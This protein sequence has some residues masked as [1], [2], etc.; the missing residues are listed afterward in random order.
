MEFERLNAL[1]GFMHRFTLRHP[2]I[3]V[4]G[5]RDEVLQRLLPW[6]L[7]EVTEMGFPASALHL[8]EQVHGAGVV[9]VQDPISTGQPLQGADGMVSN[10]PGLVLGI[11][12]ADCCA[13]FLADPVSGAF[14]LVHSGKKGSELGIAAVAIDEMQRLG[15][16]PEDIRVQLSPC[17]RPPAYEIDF[18]AQIRQDCVE[19]GVLPA[20]L[21]DDGI[22]TA[23]EVERF[24]SYRTEKG[25]TGR[26][27]ALL[28]RA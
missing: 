20:H 19:A 12:V 7:A 9:V 6:H 3:D 17:I 25:R 22:C 13:V 27:L 28:G 5:D 1:P 23:R 26:M 18:A 10:L 8:T 14:G 16:R 4:D 2:D 21:W 15:A 11:Y 24:Y